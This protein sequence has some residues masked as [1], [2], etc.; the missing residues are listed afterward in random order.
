MMS[1]IEA[2]SKRQ[3]EHM[4]KVTRSALMA[5]GLAAAALGSMPAL[6]D[7]GHGNGHDKHGDWDGDH[8][9][10]HDRG[11]HEGWHDDHDHGR[12]QGWHDDHDRGRPEAWHD[13]HRGGPPAWAPAH[14]RRA[15]D[16]HDW[17]RYDYNH[18]EPGHAAY[19]ADHYYRGG[20]RPI[21]VHRDTRIY[22]GYDDHYYCRRSDGTTGLIVGA[23]LGGL[24]GNS[25]DRGHS[26]ALGTILGA[27]AGG[28]IGHSIDSGQVV[29]R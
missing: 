5:I 29:C 23:A 2:A 24:L 14:G 7:P 15:N 1:N 22:R 6:A 11:R 3:G 20:Y 13:D 27:S 10:G 9:H 25:L 16:W 4:R 17:H 12:P 19:Y 28:L 8:D 26:S 21:V 18:Y